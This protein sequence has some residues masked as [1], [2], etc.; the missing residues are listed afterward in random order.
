MTKNYDAILALSDSL[1]DALYAYATFDL[2]DLTDEEQEAQ[3]DTCRDIADFITFCMD[4]DAS[5]G[6]DQ[7]SFTA[8]GKF[9]NPVD[10]IK[11]FLEA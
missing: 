8:T 4:I 6:E 3:R 9:S 1:A 2:D 10:M 5:L 7:K 11:K